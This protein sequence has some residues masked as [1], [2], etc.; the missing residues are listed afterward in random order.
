[1]F[2]ELHEKGTNYPMLVNVSAIDTVI[3]ENSERMSDPT[4]VLTIG[5]ERYEVVES[6]EKILW[7]LLDDTCEYEE[8]ID[9]GGDS[10]E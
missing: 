8:V 7:M 3:I 5:N 2:I 1:M 6:Y 4:T 9:N 10:T